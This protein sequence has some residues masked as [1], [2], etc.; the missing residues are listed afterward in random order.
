MSAIL[1][2]KTVLKVKNAQ[3]IG[4][5]AQ[6]EVESPQPKMSNFSWPKRATKGSSFLG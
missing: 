5:L 4:C 2:Y 3:L 1:S 6:I